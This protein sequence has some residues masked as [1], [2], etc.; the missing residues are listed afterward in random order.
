MRS[1]KELECHELTGKVIGGRSPMVERFHR[2]L[3][4]HRGRQGR[5][6]AVSMVCENRQENIFHSSEHSQAE[7]S[8]PQKKSP[9]P[10]FIE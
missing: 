9:P 7:R 10:F 4:R 2:S 3:E 8:R 6:Q 1:L 5:Q